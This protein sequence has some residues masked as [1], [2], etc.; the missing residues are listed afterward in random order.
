MERLPTL[1]GRVPRTGRYAIV[2][3]LA[4][5]IGSA[6]VVEAAPHLHLFSL[7]DFTNPAQ[8]A[9]VDAAGQVSTMDA[10]THS[11]LDVANGHLAK[12]DKLTVDTNGNLKVTGTSTVGGTVNVGNFPTDGSGNLRVL[13]VN[14]PVTPVNVLA[15]NSSTFQTFFKTVTTD[16]LGQID[17]TGILPTG[18]AN[19]LNLE[20]TQFPITV[21]G[22]TVHVDMG[23]ISGSTLAAPID[24]FPLSTTPTIH[25][26][27]VVG[28]EFRVFLKGG[29]PNTNVGIQA[30]TYLR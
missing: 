21:S 22:L 8:T 17:L 4:F 18:G 30:W 12:L 7:A 5:T 6:T 19:K 1:L 3:A 11:R 20:I 23:K 10:G 26:Y 14:S 9:K 16:Q 15:Q 13:V 27:D 24:S 28:P 2:A 29:P 25:T